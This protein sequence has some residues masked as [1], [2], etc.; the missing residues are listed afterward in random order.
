MGI[1]TNEKLDLL[2]QIGT[3][4]HNIKFGKIF[5]LA[6]NYTFWV[7]MNMIL[8]VRQQWFSNSSL[9]WKN[10]NCAAAV[11]RLALI[12]I[13]IYNCKTYI[14]IAI[15]NCMYLSNRR[16]FSFVNLY[17]QRDKNVAMCKE[18]QIA[19]TLQLLLRAEDFISRAQKTYKVA[20]LKL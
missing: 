10:E 19:T 6:L 17:N 8:Q 9:V 3:H 7:K 2:V 18:D 16:L 12:K 5:N 4:Q 15:V 1:L 11:T 20:C 14:C 13:G